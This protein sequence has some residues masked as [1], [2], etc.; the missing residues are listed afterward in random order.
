MAGYCAGAS[1]AV[2]ATR[3]NCETLAADGLRRQGVE[4]YAPRFRQAATNKVVALFPGY[5]FLRPSVS[6]RSILSTRGVVAMVTGDVLVP[7]SEIN[8]IR[9]REDREGLVELPDPYTPGARV[10]IR[11]RSRNRFEP[12]HW[13]RGVT[14]GMS[15][16]ERVWVLLEFLG[17]V[18]R[19]RVNRADLVPVA[20]AP[21]YVVC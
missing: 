11:R 5:L 8:Q 20:H 4:S 21:G 7:D 14:D 15:T 18:T 17:T 6:W 12:E 16:R 19:T 2:V 1:W 10:L 3:S 13:L 9:A